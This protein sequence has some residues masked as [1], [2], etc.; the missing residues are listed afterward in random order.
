[1]GNPPRVRPRAPPFGPTLAG[2][3]LACLGPRPVPHSC[4]PLPY[5]G[6]PP[7]ARDLDLVIL[8]IS[9]ALR[10]LRPYLALVL[11]LY[12]SSDLGRVV[13]RNNN[14]CQGLPP[15]GCPH[16]TRRPAAP[17]VHL[18]LKPVLLYFPQFSS[19]SSSCSSLRATPRRAC[20][21]VPLQRNAVLLGV[22][23]PGTRIFAHAHNH[24]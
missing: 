19:S 16:P 23:L 1:M 6:R 17:Q 24:Q 22:P 2:F 21:R 11:P 8:S 9:D 3:C 14:V 7:F 5:F 10:L 18:S 15:G 20:G 4:P 12:T 13:G